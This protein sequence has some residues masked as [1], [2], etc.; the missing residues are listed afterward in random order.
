MSEKIFLNGAAQ[1]ENGEYFLLLDDAAAE[2][3]EDESVFAVARRSDSILEVTELSGID[4]FVHVATFPKGGFEGAVACALTADGSLHFTDGER[5]W[6]EII[7]DESV[8]VDGQRTLRRMRTI[9]L[10][11][12]TLYATGFGSQVYYRKQGEPWSDISFESPILTGGFALFY[13][14]VMSDEGAPV[15]AGI[16]AHKRELTDEIKAASAAGNAELFL[17]LVR[18]A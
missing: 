15:F 6:T 9:H 7:P 4:E 2:E 1:H 13:H 14:L 11:N 12:N 17:Q 3:D 16:Y 10:T 8:I 5:I 18:A